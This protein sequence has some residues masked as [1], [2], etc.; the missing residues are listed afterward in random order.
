MVYDRPWKSFEQQLELL[1][2]RGMVIG[3]RDSALQYLERI[4]Y[5]RLSAY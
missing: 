2:S 5:Y 4:G 3:D 1:E